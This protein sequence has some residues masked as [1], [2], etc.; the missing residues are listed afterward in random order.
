MVFSPDS[1]VVW[2]FNMEIRGQKGRSNNLGNPFLIANE[3]GDDIRSM[4]GVP[5][6]TFCIS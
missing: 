3:V 1:F 6:F 2:V 4:S 5:D